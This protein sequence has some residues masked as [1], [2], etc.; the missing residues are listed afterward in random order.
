MNIALGYAGMHA[1]KVYAWEGPYVERITELRN[2]EVTQIRRVTLLAVRSRRLQIA[3][4]RP[5]VTIA[6][7]G[8]NLKLHLRCHD[9][10]N[11]VDAV[12]SVWCSP[13]VLWPL[14]A[15]IWCNRRKKALLSLISSS[16]NQGATIYVGIVVFGVSDGVLC[17]TVSQ[18]SY[19]PIRRQSASHACNRLSALDGYHGVV[20]LH[21]EM[22]PLSADLPTHVGL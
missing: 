4:R 6:C 17:I 11:S 19:L 10:V 7:I 8:F 5:L 21:G 18:Q 13:L 16:V 20:T 3:R 2:E 1:I 14:I 12:A 22:A 15:A 9:C